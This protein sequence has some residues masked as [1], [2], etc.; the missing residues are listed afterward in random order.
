MQR[1]ASCPRLQVRCCTLLKFWLFLWFYCK[2]HF[3]RWNIGGSNVFNQAATQ[4]CS[5]GK[6][7]GDISL[8]E[9]TNRT[10]SLGVKVLVCHYSQLRLPF[11]CQMHEH[12]SLHT[13]NIYGIR[14][15]ITNT[16]NFLLH[17][18]IPHLPSKN[19]TEV[20]QPL[21]CCRHLQHFISP[22]LPGS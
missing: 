8:L 22:R 3:T 5:E 21:C 10:I 11:H 13:R 9:A 6:D 12:L 4:V 20:S 17:T 1:G 14:L 2:C 16:P 7:E 15:A 19:I 18:L